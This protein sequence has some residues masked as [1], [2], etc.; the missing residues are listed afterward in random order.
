MGGPVGGVV[1]GRIMRRIWKR[2]LA[3]L[4]RLVEQGR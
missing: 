1:G 4:A 3:E 2:N